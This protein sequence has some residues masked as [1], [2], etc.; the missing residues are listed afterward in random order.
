MV[1]V[2][3]NITPDPETGIMFGW[4]EDAFVHRFLA[5][6]VYADSPMPWAAYARMTDEDLR[7]IYAYLM[8]LEPVRN[9]IGPIYTAAK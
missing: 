8:S 3:P 6:R 4:T 2:T 9:D 5:G 7:A 1:Y